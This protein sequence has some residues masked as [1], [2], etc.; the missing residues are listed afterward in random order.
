MADRAA[1]ALGDAHAAV[2]DLLA[3]DLTVGTDAE[4]LECYRELER[5]ARRLAAVEHAFITEVA[6]RCIPGQQAKASTAG[7]VRA[8]LRLQPADATARVKAAEAAGPRRA[9]TGEPLPPLYPV[10]AAAQAAARSRPGTGK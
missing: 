5:L 10:V 8:L 2:D 4:L 7:F 9:L 1:V 3:A 6:A